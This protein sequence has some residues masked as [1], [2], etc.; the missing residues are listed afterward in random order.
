MRIVVTGGAGFIGSHLT[1]ALIKRGE[2]VRVVDDLSTGRKARLHKN[3]IF[4]DQNIMLDGQLNELIEMIEPDLICHLA[5]QI[6]VRTSVK[7]PASDAHAN[8]IGTINVL[9]AA[10]NVSARMIF[11]SSGGALYGR[12][13]PIPSPET[14]PPEPWSP[15]GIAKYSAEQYVEL[16]NRLH[17][18]S[19]AILRLA[20]VYGPRQQL[21][22]E[23]GV[24]PI[25]CSRT[26]FGDRIIIY[27]DGKQTRDYIYVGDVVTAFLAVVDRNIPG[28]WNIG[29]GTEVS[30]LDLALIIGEIS[31]RPVEPEFA[32]ARAGELER[33]ALS[34]E[35]AART[36]GWRPSTAL[37]DGVTR[38]YRWIQAG[39][40]DRANA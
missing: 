30:V 4:Y 3:A 37:T 21:S 25:F 5:A 9:E 23:T 32:P 28:T 31:G 10:R 24:V 13:G 36:L 40:E 8:V 2:E 27:G 38:V 39:A 11:C 22:G 35:L 7:Q 12:H 14:A 29:T 18:A 1:D 34:A 16:Y 17:S 20:N 26:L 15:Y 33:S 19:H 6:D